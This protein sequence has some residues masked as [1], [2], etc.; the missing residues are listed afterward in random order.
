M[1]E[2]DYIEKFEVNNNEK[3]TYSINICPLSNTI[4]FT[5]KYEGCIYAYVVGDFNSWKKSDEYKLNWQV[6]TSDGTLK[7]IKEIKFP[8][9]L[10]PGEYRYKYI[11]I[12]CDGNEIWIDSEG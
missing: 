5:A 7:M 8:S 3:G 12:D 9:T 6:D 2:T 1:N 10:K 11:L 4:R